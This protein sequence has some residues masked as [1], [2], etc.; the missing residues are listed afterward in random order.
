MHNSKYTLTML[1]FSFIAGGIDKVPLLP[2][3]VLDHLANRPDGRQILIYTIRVEIVQRVR[4]ARVSIWASEVNAHLKIKQYSQLLYSL[5]YTTLHLQTKCKCSATGPLITSFNM[6]KKTPAI[7]S[8]YLHN[9]WSYREVNLAT[10]HHIIQKWILRL[11]LKDS[12]GISYYDYCKTDLQPD[13]FF[14]HYTKVVRTL[15]YLILMTPE[16]L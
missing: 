8:K 14:K 2:V 7:K 13:V 12:V 10:S 3:I 15:Q 9:Y 16:F 1:P 11:K 4:W 5:N 6:K